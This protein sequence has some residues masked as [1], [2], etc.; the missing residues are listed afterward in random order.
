MLTET[1]AEVSKVSIFSTVASNMNKSKI[2]E[3][4]MGLVPDLAKALDKVR[5]CNAKSL[6]SHSQKMY[7]CFFNVILKSQFYKSL[8]AL[9]C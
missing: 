1:Y 7:Y 4:L 8:I 2:A 3:E 6:I 5:K 9:N